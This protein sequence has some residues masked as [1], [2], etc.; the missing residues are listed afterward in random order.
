MKK[1]FFLIMLIVITISCSNHSRR[2]YSLSPFLKDRNATRDYLNR[3]FISVPEGAYLT[4]LSNKKHPFRANW[5]GDSHIRNVAKR[6]QWSSHGH[7]H[8]TLDLSE[9]L[10]SSH[11]QGNSNIMTAAR[12]LNHYFAG[13]SN[14]GFRNMGSPHVL[15]SYPVQYASNAWFKEHRSN[16]SIVGSVYV[17]IE[18]KTALVAVDISEVY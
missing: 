2:S 13:L 12:L 9:A 10:L 5:P 15:S 4:K 8:F 11:E 16:I 3:S 14:L 7:H 18:E 1:L 17:D 6:Q